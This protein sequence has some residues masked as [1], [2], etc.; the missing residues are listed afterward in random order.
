MRILSRV[1]EI[2]VDRVDMLRREG[3]WFTNPRP[4][5]ASSHRAPTLPSSCSLR[6]AS[7]TPAQRLELVRGARSKSLAPLTM[8]G[9]TSHASNR[10]GGADPDDALGTVHRCW[11]YHL[12]VEDLLTSTHRSRSCR[13]SEPRTLSPN[14]SRPVLQSDVGRHPGQPWSGSRPLTTPVDPGSRRTR[15]DLS[16]GTRSMM[17]RAPCGDDVGLGRAGRDADR[18]R[19]AAEQVDRGAGP[20]RRRAR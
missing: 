9:T 6:S 7:P 3:R 15:S 10:R 8:V 14:V 18:D 11:H 12:L 4:S 1:A 2:N 20:C 5:A 19:P 17:V 13:R 16:S